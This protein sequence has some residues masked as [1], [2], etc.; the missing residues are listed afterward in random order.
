MMLGHHTVAQERHDRQ[1]GSEH[2][3]AGLEEECSERDEGAPGRDRA[4][5]RGRHHERKRRRSVRL[6]AGRTL[7]GIHRCGAA[8]RPAHLG[9]GIEAD[10]QQAGPEDDQDGF[11]AGSCRETEHRRADHPQPPVAAV[12]EF[13]QFHG[14]DGDDRHHRRRDAVEQRR[15]DRQPRV[16][17]VQRADR[18]DQQERGGDERQRHRQRPGCP[19]AQVA[20]PH[21]D[22]RGQRAGHGLTQ[23]HPVEE[24]APIDP[25]AMFD[26]VALHVA[27]GGDRTPEP[28]SAQPHE[29]AQHPNEPHLRCRIGRRRRGLIDVVGGGPAS[30]IVTL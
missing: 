18:D 21:R 25:P 19:F 1:P 3:R 17:R 5:R 13:D 20:H 22:L 23:R 24:V 26:Q 9:A 27:D 7:L 14:G 16:P 6:V 28:G 30:L 8:T 2:H 15:H 11:G 10:H 12:G 4:E 29:I